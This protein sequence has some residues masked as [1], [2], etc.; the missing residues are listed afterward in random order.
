[1]SEAIPTEPC[2]CLEPPPLWQLPCAVCRGT[3]RIVRINGSLLFPNTENGRYLAVEV[4]KR[5]KP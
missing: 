5:I 1:M 3:G 2:Y 4:E